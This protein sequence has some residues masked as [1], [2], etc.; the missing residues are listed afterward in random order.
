M[1]ETRHRSRGS[2]EIDIPEDL[3][4]ATYIERS[5][6]LL[7]VRQPIPWLSRLLMLPLLFGAG[8]LFRS[9]FLSI[10][11][12]IGGVK[13]SELLAGQI[14]CLVLGLLVGVPGLMGFL[15]RNSLV[16]DKAKGRVTKFYDF[17]LFSIPRSFDL[18]HVSLI[19]I[20]WEDCQRENTTGP[21]HDLFNVNMLRKMDHESTMVAFFDTLREATDLANELSAALGI[22]V[23]DLSDTEP[24]EDCDPEELDAATPSNPRPRGVLQ[25][26]PRRTS[27]P[28]RPSARPHGSAPAHL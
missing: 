22:S 17:R 11:D 16:I 25:G 10:G 9:L 15:I 23:R 26:N 20:T 4:L 21:G 12:V 3:I 8:Y 24:D 6:D 7:T 5:G 1:S 13:E 2:R 19:T 18:S 27:N 14:V 28:P